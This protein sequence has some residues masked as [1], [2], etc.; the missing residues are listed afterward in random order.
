M[1]KAFSLLLLLSGL[2]L[3]S[4][5]T[6]SGTVYSKSDGSA[7]QGA[8][9]K[10]AKTAYQTVT[11]ADGSFEI[12]DILPGR[13]TLLITHIDF[14]Q[15]IK[16][17]VEIEDGA[18]VK[19][20]LGL[21]SHPG[22]VDRFMSAHAQVKSKKHRP[23]ISKPK[24][25][26]P[27]P[28]PIKSGPD[29]YEFFSKKSKAAKSK[30][31]LPSSSGL[32]AGY[33]DDNQQFNYFLDFLEK[34]KQYRRY[35]LPVSERIRLRITDRSEKALANARV[36]I[37]DGKTLLEQ[38]KSY[39]D[40]SYFIFPKTY[41]AH[42]EQF[43]VRVSYLNSQKEWPVL[44]NG[45]RLHTV[46]MDVLRPKL[47]QIPLDLLFILDTTGSM[48]EEIER[49]KSTIELINL[50]L[51]SLNIH[52]QIRYGMVLYRDRE[53]DYDTKIIPFTSDLNVFR[54]AL[55]Q[56]SADGGGD[57]PED[58]QAALEAALHKMKWNSE[59]IRLAYIITDASLHT[60]YGQTFTYARAARE[61]KTKGIK[62]F[63][64]GTGGL[65]IAGE[66]VLRQVAQ[67][68]YGKYIFLTYGEKG[69]SAGGTI[70]SVSHHTGS[71]FNAENLEAVI[72][73][74]TKQ[75]LG[76]Q[77][78]T[79]LQTETSYFEADKID[80]ESKQQTLDKLFTQATQELINFSALK[81]NAK[82]P[83]AILPFSVRSNSM[84]N[85]AEYFT[86]EFVLAVRKQKLLRLVERQD[87][88]RITEE[89]GLRLSGLTDEQNVS[90]LGQLIGADLLISGRLYF[91]DGRYEIFLKLLRV[92]TGEVLSVT[93]VRL[94]TKL[95]L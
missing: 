65:D 71:N 54:K 80:D 58:L 37:W 41:S 31:G 4:G 26:M 74:F 16:K 15:L 3:A 17:D 84:A 53:D 90:Q 13:Y 11:D 43:R 30:E 47:K 92:E 67:F 36:E 94:D 20:R 2:A 38:G 78:E 29:T 42:P 95:G 49:L 34:Y 27:V 5:G 66:Y 7:V 72:I 55:N 9:V 45:A 68:T 23:T 1:F 62:F 12:R 75:E 44:R 57:T 63:T 18:L 6:L 14:I 24:E 64:V 61:A 87:L 48:G 56:V 81:I 39:A 79:P 77:S 59:A 10:L 40:G 85:N 93:R 46:K 8:Q 35:D 32:R 25:K 86:Q 22:D 91:N 51:S 83:A 89:I 69:E 28:P 60:D 33:A 82:M 50:N 76:W 88:Q 70:G 19:L 52:P 73:R 21:D